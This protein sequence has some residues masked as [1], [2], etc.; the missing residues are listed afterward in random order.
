MMPNMAIILAA[1]ASPICCSSSGVQ[2]REVFDGALGAV[3]DGLGFL[4]ALVDLVLGA[5]HDAAELRVQKQR[6]AAGERENRNGSLHFEFNPPSSRK[7]FKSAAVGRLPDI[8]FT[9]CWS[10]APGVVASICL[11][12]LPDGSIPLKPSVVD[13]LVVLDDL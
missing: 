7:A 1:V 5:V 9:F 2:A 8:F 13:S 3:A 6:G 11:S 12:T 10:E 4:L